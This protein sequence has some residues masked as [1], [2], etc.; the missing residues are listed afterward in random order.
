MLLV[1]FTLV[2]PLWAEN[3]E[4]LTA[5]RMA[6]LEE[7]VER[8]AALETELDVISQR[9]E[10][11]ETTG[12][13]KSS[14]DTC[15]ACPAWSVRLEYLNWAVRRHD[16]DFAIATDDTALAVGAG[17]VQRVEL[18]RGSGVRAGIAYLTRSNWEI[19]FGYTYFHTSGS[20]F[21]VEP[22]RGNLW[23][24][25]S[26]PDR[27]EEATEAAAEANLDYHVFDLDA[28]HA[29]LANRCT[30]LKV[31]GG[32]RWADIDQDLLIRYRGR[33]FGNGLVSQPVDM[34]AFGVRVGMDGYW[35]LRGGW[36]LFGRGA[37]SIMYGQFEKQMLET[38][39]SGADTIVDVTDNYERAV[40]VLEA[41]VGVCWACTWLEISGGYEVQ[42][43][44][45]MG[46]RSTF[47][48]DVHE[49]LYVP[50]ASDILL[51]G[52]FLRCAVV[53]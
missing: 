19:A 40:P 36:S 50:V 23:A 30:A 46:D 27:N 21:A 52:F 28:G 37:G 26:H 29:F 49:G 39:V 41:A 12:Y 5:G 44:L 14:A 48:D 17:A 45:N 53:F 4:S 10:S 15:S 31:F 35:H 11:L 7:Y 2:G 3:F 6:V 22:P 18:D 42:S 47:V 8:T 13:A 32:V 24:T 20:A 1:G 9:L 51:D 25:R 38:N 16:L 43:W 34:E 33:D